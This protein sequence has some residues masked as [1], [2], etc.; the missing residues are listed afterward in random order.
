[1]S[2]WPG[3]IIRKTPVTPTGPMTTGSA[4]G[5][6]S[7][8][9]AAYWTKQGLWPS[10]SSD[11]YWSSVTMLMSTTALNGQQNNTF[12]D[13][14]TNNFTITA[15]GTPVQGAVTPFKPSSY[16]LAGF[17]GYTSAVYG[18]SAYL[19]GTSSYLYTPASTAFDLGGGDFT[20]EGWYYWNGL[21]A[22][23]HFFQIGVGPG[24]TSRWNVY[25]DTPNFRLF[26]NNGGTVT[27][28]TT[29]TAVPTNTWF[30]LAVTKLGST[31][32][33]FLNGTSIGT[34]TSVNYP[35]G[36]FFAAIGTQPISPVSS[37]YFS[38]YVSNFRIVKGTAVYTANFTPP[39]APLTA[40]TNTQLL[41]NMTNAGIYDSAMVNDMQTA[42]DAK[43]S[44]AQ[45]KF[46]TTS[47]AF[48]GTGDYAVS[49][50][51]SAFG[52]GTGDFTIEFWLY[53]NSTASQTVVSNLTS[54]AST[55]P[56]IYVDG[57]IYYYTN[58]ANRIS[59][60]ALSTG[61]W[62]HIAVARASGSTKMFVNGTQVG[63]TYADSNNYGSTAPLGVATYWS[64]GAPVT[65]STLNG[66]IDELRITKG[67]AR[68]TANF[69]PP[70][71]AF[72][73]F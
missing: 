47:A 41:L 73:I 43:V 55:N 45:A 12:I 1:M 71:Q 64:G 32:T 56:H 39:T 48:D 23:P 28:I 37:D 31:T 50:S 35:S 6:W 7:M 14:S 58:S 2:R 44:T 18:G 66:Y 30:H 10:G 16:P 59:S 67:V 25:R 63:S 42:G 15:N 26:A 33:L 54:A 62:Y 19:E 46:G 11:P 24:F 20:V 40:I 61:Q 60:S 4:S 17:S 8:A 9:D 36:T 72:P 53:L 27:G 69:T 38:G 70:T 57:S 3:G 5:V 52:Y 51:S 49:P 34:S 65:S 68:Y 21:N 29:T 22:T 13:G